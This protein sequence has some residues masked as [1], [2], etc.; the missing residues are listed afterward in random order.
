MKIVAFTRWDPLRDILALHEQL[1]H[2]VGTDAPGW[3]PPV[4]LYETAV[5][6]IGHVGKDDRNGPRDLAQRHQN[7]RSDREE[8]RGIHGGEFRRV[9]TDATEIIT[10]EPH[11]F[12]AWL[13][14]RPAS[15]SPEMPVGNPR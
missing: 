14:A 3:T 4:D 8:H 15:A 13:K 5:D 9:G 12:C 7:G 2:L 11:I 10:H 1:G 6:R